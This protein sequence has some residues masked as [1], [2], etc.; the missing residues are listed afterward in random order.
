MILLEDALNII[1]TREIEK[2]AEQV[3]WTDSMNRILAEDIISDIE[4]P[5]FN[6]S[7]MDGYA[8]RREDLHYELDEIE[9]IQAGKSPTKKIGKNQCAKIMTGSMMPEGAD[10]VIMVEDTFKTD[11][12]KIKF[13]GDSTK[14][15]YVPAGEDARI[16]DVMLNKGKI[17]KPQDIALMSAVGCTEPMVSKKVRVG[18]LS[19]GDELVEPYEKPGISQIRNS[20]A[21]QLIAQIKRTG[22]LPSYYGI[23][24]DDPYKSEMLIKKVLVEN[25]V[26]ILT[27]GVS[28]GD[29]DF[30]PDILKKIGIKIHFQTIAVQPGK[31][32]VFGT[33]KDKIVFGLPG[34]PVSSFNIFELVV[35][36]LLYKMMG[37]EYQPVMIKLP[38][39]KRYIRRRSNRKSFL[40]VKIKD[41]QVIPLEYHGSAHIHALTEA[42]GLIEIPI[43]VTTLNEGTIVNVRQI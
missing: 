39:G 10:C 15:N 12:N 38:I 4:M 21:F 5:P 1:L 41:D 22:G 9:S 20:N 24:E 25:E 19:T 43:G 16:G 7:A 14:D 17:I 33:L 29:Y 11:S 28:M 31:P 13:T 26:T 8:C 40:P 2:S 36:P 3:D 32:T 6:K 23:V 30:I 35:R 37:H 34:N 42:M 27:G 18:I